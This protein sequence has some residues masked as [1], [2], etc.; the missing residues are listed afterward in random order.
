MAP[1]TFTGSLFSTQEYSFLHEIQATSLEEAETMFKELMATRTYGM[2]I[3]LEPVD[4]AYDVSGTYN[5]FDKPIEE[6]E[7]TADYD[8]MVVEGGTF[9]GPS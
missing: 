5:V 7:D 4:T 1:Y 2:D 8:E 3:E 9:D 6:I